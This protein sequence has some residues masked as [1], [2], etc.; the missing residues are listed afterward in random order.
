M[1]YLTLLTRQ[2]W[3]RDGHCCPPLPSKLCVRLSNYAPSGVRV[4]EA[5][6]QGEL[7]CVQRD[8]ERLRSFFNASRLTFPTTETSTP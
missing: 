6:A 8:Q 1:K 3:V 5:L 2:A 7:E 4:L